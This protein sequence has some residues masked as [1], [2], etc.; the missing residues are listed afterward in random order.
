MTTQH[1]PRSHF[2]VS[3]PIV[4]PLT[5]SPLA[6]VDAASAVS[7]TFVVPEGRGKI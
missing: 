4:K 2:T 6:Q 3:R 5:G 7:E 1:I